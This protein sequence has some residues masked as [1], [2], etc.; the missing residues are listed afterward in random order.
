MSTFLEDLNQSANLA[1]FGPIYSKANSRMVG[2]NPKTKK[3]VNIKPKKAREAVKSFV[4]QAKSQWC[5]RNH[6][7][8]PIYVKMDIFYQSRRPDLDDSLICDCLEKAGVIGNDRFIFHKILT[9]FLDPKNP[10]VESE[11]RWVEK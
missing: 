5:R 6:L 3:Q 1:L 10:R 2:F 9:K 11:L 4:Y 7:E 8:A